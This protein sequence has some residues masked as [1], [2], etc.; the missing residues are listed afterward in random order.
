M[1]KIN[2]AIQLHISIKMKLMGFVNYM[3]GLQSHDSPIVTNI[4]YNFIEI[5]KHPVDSLI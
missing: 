1:N 5:F 2:C 4:I 3:V